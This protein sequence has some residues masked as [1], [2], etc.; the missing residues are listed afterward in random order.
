MDC[1]CKRSM[2]GALC[3]GCDLHFV[4]CTCDELRPLRHPHELTDIQRMDLMAYCWF[5]SVKLAADA[6][7]K[8]PKTIR[9]NLVV[10]RRKLGVDTTMQA[11][12]VLI[13][14]QQDLSPARRPRKIREAGESAA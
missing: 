1:W 10:V 4:D 8:S 7:G 3:S 13:G 14:Q 6:L 5:G 2:T 9:N 12:L 11:L